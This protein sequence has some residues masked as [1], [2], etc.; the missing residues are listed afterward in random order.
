MSE[1][2]QGEGMERR[3]PANGATA[4]ADTD[5][6]STEPFVP[7]D[8]APGSPDFAQA[9]LDEREAEHTNIQDAHLEIILDVPLTLSVEIGRAR[10]T[11]RDLLQ[12]NAGSVVKLD[13]LAGDPM[14]IMVNGCLIA[15]GEVVVAGET[16]GIRITAVVSPEERIKSL[17]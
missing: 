2:G 17:R 6:V 9:A 3:G 12:L 7:V 16:F 11:I 13:R 1:V 8:I 14:D 10:L 5:S 4:P 15:K